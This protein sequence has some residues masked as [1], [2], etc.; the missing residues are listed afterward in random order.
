MATLL[1]PVFTP[2]LQTARPRLREAETLWA[3]GTR[4]SW[5]SDPGRVTWSLGCGPRARALSVPAT[6]QLT[7][8]GDV[9]PAR[10][11]PGTQARQAD[12]ELVGVCWGDL[13]GHFQKFSAWK[14][15]C[16]VGRVTWGKALG[17]GQAVC[18]PWGS[19]VCRRDGPGSPTSQGRWHPGRLCGLVKGRVRGPTSHPT[20]PTSLASGQEERPADLGSAAC[21]AGAPHPSRPPC[22]PEAGFPFSGL[23]S[24][25]R[26]WGKGVAVLTSGP[27][28]GLKAPPGGG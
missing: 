25:L 8:C 28:S 1:G 18:R 12:V 26:T 4:L 7:S 15:A 20:V 19:A 17:S 27:A 21:G 23:R 22:C 3:A 16:P 10:L 5:D 24:P 13:G 6:G 2:S 9:S 14:S 11:M